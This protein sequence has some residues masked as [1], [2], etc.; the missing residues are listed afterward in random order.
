M[1]DSKSIQVKNMVCDRCIE[2]VESILKELNLPFEEV[3]LG[4]IQLSAVADP[5]QIRMLD[6]RL[7]T[8]GFE[9]VED[10]VQRWVEQVKAAIIHLV[11]HQ[12]ERLGHQN[13]SDFLQQEVGR[14]YSSLSKVFTEQ[15]GRTIQE[16]FIAQRILKAI[17]L[18]EYG[19][20]N[21]S[22]IASELGFSS[23]PHF[24]RQFRAFTHLSPSE[25]KKEPSKRIPLDQL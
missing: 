2:A 16:Y 5:D 13:L 15:E 3:G 14:D 19:E 7:Q 9:R 23:L 8:R 22:Q 20:L 1:K 6:D 11:H 18:L 12:P 17:E 10:P 25:W 21:L 4:R 24:S